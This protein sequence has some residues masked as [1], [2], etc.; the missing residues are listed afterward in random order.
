M[1]IV[2]IQ[3]TSRGATDAIFQINGTK[4]LIEVVAISGQYDAMIASLNVVGFDLVTADPDLYRAT[5]WV[6]IGD[7]LLLNDM[8]CPLLCPA[9]LSGCE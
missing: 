6:E 5:G 4:V 8:A 1:P 3:L 2:S 7:L 9:G